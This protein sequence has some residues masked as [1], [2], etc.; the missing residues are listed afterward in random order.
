[1]TEKALEAWAVV[2]EYFSN[3][4]STWKEAGITHYDKKWI[5]E[6]K[7]V[8]LDNQELRFRNVRIETLVPKSL[9]DAAITERDEARAEAKQWRDNMGS[10]Y[11]LPWEEKH[12]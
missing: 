7:R 2:Y 4:T 8:F 10:I 5:D 11:P 12:E 6:F 3:E 9:L 1:M